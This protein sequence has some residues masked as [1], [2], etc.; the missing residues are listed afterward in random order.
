MSDRNLQVVGLSITEDYYSYRGAFRLCCGEK[1]MDIELEELTD[2]KIN[3]IKDVFGL[4]GSVQDIKNEIMSK[5][6]E[7]SGLES[8]FVEGKGYR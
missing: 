2:S 1:Y 8:R 5:V 4:D 7:A 6:L 3:E